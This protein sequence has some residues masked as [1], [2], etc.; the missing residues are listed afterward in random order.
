[1]TDPDTMKR[2]RATYGR[3]YYDG[4]KAAKNQPQKDENPMGTTRQQAIL[5]GLT[6]TSR[7]VY[8]AMPI[9]ESW[10]ITKIIAELRRRGISTDYSSVQGSLVHLL[11]HKCIK[12]PLKGQ[13]IRVEMKE[14]PEKAKPEKTKLAFTLVEPTPEPKAVPQPEKAPE[15]T[16]MLDALATLAESLKAAGWKLIGQ[17]REVE[18]LAL[19][20][21]AKDQTMKQDYERVKQLRSLLAD[22]GK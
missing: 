10:T 11:D 2:Q 16:G 18:E 9:A 4:L 5:D 20:L 21:E 17:A 3:G 14:E 12:E 1:M 7:K 15:E 8:E 19:R 22:L 13:Y 6:G